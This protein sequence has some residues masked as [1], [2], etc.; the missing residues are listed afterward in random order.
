MNKEQEII[1]DDFE[2]FISGH[3]ISLKVLTEMKEMVDQLH[4]ESLRV[5]NMTDEDILKGA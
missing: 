3:R 5:E 4:E 2:N 1:L